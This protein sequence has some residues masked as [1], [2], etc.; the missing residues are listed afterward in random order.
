MDIDAQAAARTAARSGE[1]AQHFSNASGLYSDARNVRAERAASNSVRP[2]RLHHAAGTERRGGRVSSV[3]VDDRRRPAARHPRRS[4][5]VRR[6]ARR[7]RKIN[8]S[9]RKKNL[10]HVFFIE[11]PYML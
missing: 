1:W 9:L 3:S 8:N 2:G 11:S 7:R 5:H 4:L 10:R 6:D